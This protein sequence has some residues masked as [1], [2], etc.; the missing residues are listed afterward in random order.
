VSEFNDD[1]VGNVEFARSKPP[2]L[3]L[4]SFA[5][6]YKLGDPCLLWLHRYITP[7]GHGFLPR[8]TANHHQVQSNC[9]TAIFSPSR[10]STL[11]GI[12][13]NKLSGAVMLILQEHV[14]S[15]VQEALKTAAVTPADIACIAYTKVCIAQQRSR[16]NN[17]LDVC[18]D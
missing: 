3:Q 16:I 14:V 7:P 1:F 8:Q 6:S 17:T 4:R 13:W 18:N 2:F 11:E 10:F 9:V 15:L 5:C 12:V